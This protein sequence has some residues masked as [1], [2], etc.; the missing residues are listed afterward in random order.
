MIQQDLFSSN[1]K[2]KL[3]KFGIE[4]NIDTKCECQ[5][6]SDGFIHRIKNCTLSKIY[7][8]KIKELIGLEWENCTHPIDLFKNIK[9]QKDMTELIKLILT[10]MKKIGKIRIMLSHKY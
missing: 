10:F 5:L 9:S 8:K 7:A 4:N 1:Y 6:E 2:N 3:D